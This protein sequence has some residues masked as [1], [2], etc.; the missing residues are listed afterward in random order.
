MRT[1]S[2][3][4]NP[5][6]SPSAR[7]LA[8]QLSA[9]EHPGACVPT[10]SALTAPSA[11]CREQEEREARKEAGLPPPREERGSGSFF[12]KGS[13]DTG[14][15]YTTN[16]FVGNLAPDV[17]EQVGDVGGGLLWPDACC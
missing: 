15:P 13:F 7:K 14:D 2:S 1:C 6:C 17:D 12:D 16:L 9:W 11:F 4:P 8:A 5:P 10:L 3:H